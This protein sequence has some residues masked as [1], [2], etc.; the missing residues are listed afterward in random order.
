M[1]RAVS[2]CVDKEMAENK[3]TKPQKLAWTDW[4]LTVELS[5]VFK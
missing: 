5:T 4:L 3:A 1:N 2:K